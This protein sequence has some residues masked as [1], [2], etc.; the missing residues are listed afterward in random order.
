[1]II[2]FQ[3]RRENDVTKLAS[4]FI[5]I[6]WDILYQF[7]KVLVTRVSNLK[8]KNCIYPFKGYKVLGI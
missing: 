4:N 7:L 5:S 3:F 8:K 2:V 1:M 6:L